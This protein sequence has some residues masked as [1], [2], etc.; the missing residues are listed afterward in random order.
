[1]VSFRSNCVFFLS[2]C[3]Y[4]SF[5]NI[6]TCVC[7]AFPLFAWCDVSPRSRG[8]I[9][10]DCLLDWN[11]YERRLNGRNEISKTMMG[12]GGHMKMSLFCL[13]WRDFLVQIDR[14]ASS[15]SCGVLTLHI[16]L[17]TNGTIWPC[18]NLTSTVIYKTRKRR[19]RRRKKTR[20]RVYCRRKRE[21]ERGEKKKKWEN[22]WH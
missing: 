1:M 2:L 16:T 15:I 5:V 12:K 7:T 6:Y 11:E 17:S 22:R 13:P 9:N 3:W 21:S 14:Y 4:F 18:W 19:R 20:V 10:D 8:E